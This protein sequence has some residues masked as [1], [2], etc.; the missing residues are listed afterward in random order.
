M[1]RARA[2]DFGAKQQSI[3]D[4]AAELFAT[5]G[6]AATSTADIARACGISKALIW[7]YFESKEAI[8]EDLLRAHI[9]AL[10]AAADAALAESAD[11]RAQLRAFLRAHMRLYA[12]ARERH[13]LLVGEIEALPQRQRAGIVAKQRKLVETATR[14]LQRVAPALAAKPA[15]GWPAGMGLYGFINWTYVWFDPDGPVSPEQ[16]ADFACEVFLGG[17]AS[18]AEKF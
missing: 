8:L 18:A 13:K 11:P 5:R 2:G 15:L 14:L 6:F 3:R 9:G 12:R 17:I 10:Q 7:H 16:F 1:P 4:R